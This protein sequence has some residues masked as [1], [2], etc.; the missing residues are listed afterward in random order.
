MTCYSSPFS[1]HLNAQVCPPAQ[2][3]PHRWTDSLSDQMDVWL[4]MDTDTE[5]G[6]QPPDD[7]AADEADAE[8]GWWVAGP[9]A[10]PPKRPEAYPVGPPAWH[11]MATTLQTGLCLG[12]SSGVLRPISAALQ[13]PPSPLPQGYPALNEMGT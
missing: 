4:P 7:T 13:S 1:S 11:P 3:P 10:P 5:P 6:L 9:V 8:V 2:S 12:G